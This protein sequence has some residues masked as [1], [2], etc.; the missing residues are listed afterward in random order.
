MKI[1]LTLVITT[2]SIIL[3]SCGSGGTKSTEVPAEKSAEIVATVE[4]P[5][6]SVALNPNLASREQM[7]T[8]SG[9]STEQVDQ[10]MSNRPHLD[11]AVFAKSLKEMVG[12]DSYEATAKQLF[13]PMNLDTTAEEDFKLIPG[14]GNKMAHEFEEYRPYASVAQFRREIG[15]YVDEA[16]V[17]SYLQFVFVPLNLN[18]ASEEDI[19]LTPGVGKKMAHEFEEYRP[20]S[21]MEQFRREIGKYVDENEV[22]RLARFVTI[23]E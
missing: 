6:S 23:G 16:Q 8:V 10:I 22:A 14:V 5:T 3:C 1:K 19:L 18:T 9:L 13:L 20:Y 15:K 17:A 11:G 12:E 2:L 7:L 21:S 4:K